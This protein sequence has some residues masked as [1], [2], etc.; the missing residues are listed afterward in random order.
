MTSINDTDIDLSNLAAIREYRLESFLDRP[1]FTENKERKAA[2]LAGVLVGQVSWHQ[3]N[4][5][6]LG[7]PLDSKTRGDQLTKNGLEQA[8]KTAIDKAKVYAHDSEYDSDRDHIM[9][10]TDK[11]LAEATEK[12][13]ADWKREKRDLQ[14]AY[15]LGHANGRGSMPNAFDLHE[16][17]DE[18]DAA[19]AVE[20][21]AN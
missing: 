15:V 18:S 13:P 1:M 6:D 4:E 21:P 10:E 17:D 5:R 12:L 9:P 8:L 16:K 19:E 3:E 20:S 2:A 7:R 11:L 14:F